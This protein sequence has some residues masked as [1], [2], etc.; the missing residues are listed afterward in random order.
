MTTKKHIPPVREP[1][2]TEELEQLK[3]MD[4]VGL[5]LTDDEESRLREINKRGDHE[6]SERIVRVR[7]ELAPL[8][9]ELQSAGLKIQ[10]VSELNSRSERYEQAIP[11]LLRH[12]QMPYSDIVKSAIARSLAVPKPEIRKAWP[13][14]VEEYRKAP[15]GWGIKA[16]G[17]TR[18]YRLTAKDDLAHT[19]AVTVTDETLEEL[20]ELAR[21]RAQ[22]G[23]RVLLLRALRKSKNP[24]AKQAVDE[25]AND[26]Q[27]A[28]EIASWRTR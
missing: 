22:G 9:A 23:S 16:P 18:E 13:T 15:R 4:F 12:L 14:L 26:P 8:L 27:L 11:I 24:L 6:R 25:L 1:L 21:D 7:A 19:L 17:D 20:I 5:K 3:S 2:T 28:K 10:S